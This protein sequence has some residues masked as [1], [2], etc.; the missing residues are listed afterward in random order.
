MMLARRGI[1]WM[2][3][4]RPIHRALCAIACARGRG[5]VL[6]YHRIRSFAA[7]DHD[8]IPT[9]PVEVFRSHLQTLGEI[10]DLVTLGELLAP[11]IARHDIRSG[12][13]AVA[14]T[15]D[16]D[17]PSHVHDAL[18]VLRQMVVPAAFFLSG[19]ALHGLGPYWFQRL[20]AALAAHSAATIAARL[21]I[22]A[23]T[24]DRLALAC[25]QNP[26]LQ[27]RLAEISRDVPEP[28]VLQGGD[29]AALSGAGMTIG[30][31]TVEHHILPSLDNAALKAAVVHG[32]S[33][34]AAVARANVRFFAYPHGKADVRSAGA[35]RDGGFDA[36]FTGRPGATS[37]RNGRYVIGRWEPGALRV[38][39]LL[40]KL[41]IYLHRPFPT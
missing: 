34:L 25:E 15:F 33:Q 27:Q 7:G 6:V 37:R 41:A 9:V 22:P 39:D 35:V 14:V 11:A 31:H 17:L 18:P 3:R 16:D 38:D 30:F 24:P 23:S 29:I 36:A 13:P 1:T 5:L 4:A 2:L 32:R 26:E 21:G 19:R 40:V 12:R 28:S 10:A 8:V 20:E